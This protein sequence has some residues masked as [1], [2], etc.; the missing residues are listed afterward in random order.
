M[1]AEEELDK[2][3]P[4]GPYTF[5]RESGFHERLFYLW[6]RLGLQSNVLVSARYTSSRAGEGLTESGVFSALR[7]T[8][9]AHTGLAAVGVIRPGHKSG[10]HILHRVMLHS[11]DLRSCVEFVDDEGIGAGAEFFERIHNQWY[12]TAD[13]PKGP[14]WRVFVLGRRDV[15]FVFHHFVCDGR[16]GY[17]FHRTFL[18]ALN[19]SNAVSK[20]DPEPIVRFDPEKDRMPPDVQELTDIKYST[21]R[22]VLTYLYWIIIRLL[23][24]K[25]LLF[26]D[27]PPPKPYPRMATGRA[28]PSQQTVTR[29]AG[30]RLPAAKM[31]AIT[32]A[33]RAHKTTF[34]PLLIIAATA[35]LASR[36]YPRAKLG[37]TL[38][39]MDLRPLLPVP[40]T[41]NGVYVICNAAGGMAQ[42]LRLSKVRSA[43]W[44]AL[45]DKKSE[46]GAKALGDAE[47]L[48]VLVQRYKAHMDRELS[49]PVPPAVQAW[50]AGNMLGPTL[51]DMVE[52]VFPS[53]G[54]HQQNGIGFS[55]LGRFDPGTAG[56][57][58]SAEAHDQA[59]KVEEVQMSACVTGGAVSYHGLAFS[60]AGIAG[61]DTVVNVAWEEGVVNREMVNDVWDG[62]VECINAM[63]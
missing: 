56:A 49:G 12:F 59:W 25:R 31:S 5:V 42:V 52:Q 6:H 43:L 28:E 38:Y 13:E 36:V 58:D 50:L 26:S 21:F 32:A 24:S 30:F 37:F 23:F 44:R 27:V 4:A 63:V 39:P 29:V 41:S 19:S 33:C 60:I 20:S 35:T 7:E 16:S 46:A 40:T 14:W 55:N 53:L 22:V 51:E 10:R 15:V 11:I 17:D 34:T 45:G 48:W 2:T 57:R 1:A 9:K 61:G 3:D 47:D 8:I 62:I 54:L 18:A